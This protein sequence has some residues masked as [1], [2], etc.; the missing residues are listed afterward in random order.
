[1]AQRFAA[2]KL[3]SLVA[4]SAATLVSTPALAREGAREAARDT[5]L[6]QVESRLSDPNT[7]QAVGE[8]LAGMLAALMDVKAAPFVKAMDKVGK[9]AGQGPVARDIP[10]D[11]TLGDLAGPDARQAPR[12]LARQVPQMMGAMGAM[13]GAMKEMLPQLEDMAKRMGDQM[14]KSIDRAERGQGKQRD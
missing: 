13:T 3:V 12:Q 14:G 11:A 6:D 9:S 10:A 2:L 5:G 1:M 8:A 4:L 7:Q